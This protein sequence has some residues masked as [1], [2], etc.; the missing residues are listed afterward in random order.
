MTVKPL[1]NAIRLE[2]EAEPAP[3]ALTNMIRNPNGDLGGWGWLTPLAGSQIYGVP[4]AD[5]GANHLVF[6]GVAGTSYFYSEFMTLPAGMYVA[7]SWTVPALGASVQWRMRFEFFDTSGV[8]ISSSPQSAYVATTLAPVAAPASTT[9]VRLRID[10]YQDASGTNPTGNHY[11]SFN[12]VTVAKATTSTALGTSRT[13]VVPDPSFEAALTGWTASGVVTLTRDTTQHVDGVAAMRVDNVLPVRTNRVTNPNSPTAIGVWRPAANTQVAWNG[14]VGHNGLGAVR[15]LYA[16]STGNAK[17][18]LPD[19]FAAVAGRSYSASAYMKAGS[20]ARSVRLVFQW[21]NSVGTALSTSIGPSVVDSTQ[22]VF[23]RVSATFVAPANAT[24]FDVAVEIIAPANAEFHYFDAFLVEES[25]SVGDYFDGS[26]P[27]TSA[28]V[29]AWTGTPNA[30]TSTETALAQTLDAGP[31]SPKL[32][33][34]GGQYFTTSAYL[35]QIAGSAGV[36]VGL[37]YA[38]FTSDDG[39]IGYTSA[40]ALRLSDAWERISDTQA[41]PVN[42]AK[43]QIRFSAAQLDGAEGFYLDAV[44]VELGTILNPFYA[45]TF[46]TSN[47]DYIQPIPFLDILGTTHDVTISREA[48]NVGTLT[49]NIIDSTLDPSQSDAIRPGRIVRLTAYDATRVDWIPVFTGIVAHASVEYELTVP[50]ARKR[51]HVELTAVD[52]VQALAN[53]NRADGVATIAGLPYVLEGCGVPWNVNGSGS[54]V[55]SAVVVARNESA[56]ALDQISVTRD[57]VLGYAWV[58]RFGTLQAWDRSKISTVVR[59]TLDE[60]VYSDVTVAY[61]TTEL[62]NEVNVLYLRL[63]PGTGETEEVGYGPYRNVASINE[64]GVSS[65]EYTIQGIAEETS[66]LTAYAQAVLDA[67]SVP[68]LR[69]NSTTLLV[70]LSDDWQSVSDWYAFV[71]LYD[72]LA[73]S[74]ERANIDETSRVTA[75][76]HT[77]SGPDSK[78]LVEL[79]FSSPQIVASPSW[80]PSP[81]NGEGETIGELLRPVGEVTMF[82]GTKGQ[83]PAGWLAMDGTSFSS[84]TYPKLYALLGTTTLPNMT[85]RLPIGAGTKALGTSGGSPTKSLVAANLP[86]HVHD[87]LHGHQSDSRAGTGGST[88]AFARTD[89]S[90]VV[91]GGGMVKNFTGDSGNGPG[92]SAA[93]DVMNPWRALW[94][95]IRAA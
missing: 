63:N 55:A 39:L 59:G 65:A 79:G 49:A 61:N 2:V 74:N 82:Y 40:P 34:V 57:S 26:T 41:A 38:W 31:Q 53:Q 75:I 16:A 17:A 78:W 68:E 56:S 13:N 86:P 1:R 20:L 73:V 48:L 90:A 88:V 60:D 69:L 32:P 89:G 10:L 87:M 21:F 84:T 71:D 95:I 14:T 83:I 44:L 30:S 28:A 50:D 33:V 6:N 12:R 94:F 46:T 8:L 25:A 36:D 62:I 64:W 92:T 45:G 51:A 52:N 29:H 24:R 43:L 23:R 15:I 81:T 58:D 11:F 37:V 35:K 4:D 7:A 18:T 72:L 93:F 27:N 85:D 19:T 54:Q 76:R 70:H 67:N 47:L 80:I 5:D 77:I 3:G 66:A 42:A 22:S 91:T 9:Y